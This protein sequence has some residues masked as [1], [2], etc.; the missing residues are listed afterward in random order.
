MGVVLPI[1]QP[2]SPLPT[3]IS[4]PSRR[5]IT[6]TTILQP[7][8]SWFSSSKS[9]SAQAVTATPVV[10]VVTR[11]VRKPAPAPKASSSTTMAQQLNKGH[12]SHSSSSSLTSL[13]SIDSPPKKRKISER[14]SAAS[15]SQSSKR[16]RT[17]DKPAIK[18]TAAPKTKKRV[19]EYVDDDSDDDYGPKRARSKLAAPLP[20]QVFRYSRSRSTTAFEQGETPR[21]RKTWCDEDGAVGDVLISSE[22][23][24]KDLL[25]SYKACAYFVVLLPRILISPS[26]F[27]ES[28]RR[29]GRILY[30]T[31]RK[32]P[33]CRIGIP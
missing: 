10:T 4:A 3:M 24:V 12:S 20:E 22:S 27:Q 9:P 33:C 31:S 19:A 26:S 6:S 30:S 25:N 18:V 1:L 29:I 15:S 17:E 28:R 11:V 23:V 16:R 7:G 32:L 5:V 8:E 13:S 2:S 21:E 14:S